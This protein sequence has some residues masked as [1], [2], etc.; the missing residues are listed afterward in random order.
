M[1]RTEYLAKN[2]KFTMAGELLLA[3]LK[4]VSRR[5]FVVLLGKEY[6]G[7]NGLFADVHSMLSEIGR[8]HV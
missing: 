5:V 7:L 8:A 2:V 6:L 3:L 1:N 4:F